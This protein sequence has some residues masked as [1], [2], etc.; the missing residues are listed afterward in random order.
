MVVILR[1]AM[2]GLA[3]VAPYGDPALRGLRGELVPPPP[4]QPDGLLDLGGFYGLH[5]ALAG[6]ARDVSG[7]RVAAGA[8]RRRALSRRAAISR[9]RTTW[10]AAPT[11]A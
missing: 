11:T 5:P 2:D 3:A 9:R 10:R 8:R 1:G 4:G 7:G 6:L